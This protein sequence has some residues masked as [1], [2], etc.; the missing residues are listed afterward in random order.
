MHQPLVRQTVDH[1]QIPPAQAVRFT[2]RLLHCLTKPPRAG[3]VEAQ[4]ADRLGI[5]RVHRQVLADA[6]QPL[7]VEHHLHVV[8][9]VTG[10]AVHGQA[11]RRRRRR[12][13]ALDH[14]LL[15][16]RVAVEQ[17][18][19]ALE[20]VAGDP[21][22]AQVVRNLKERIELRA[23]RPAVVVTL[24][25]GL[26]GGGSIASDHRD[27]PD[28]GSQQGIELPLQQRLAVQVDEALGTI[29]GERQQAP[30]LAGAQDD[31]LHDWVRDSATRKTT[32]RDAVAGP[33]GP[34]AG[35]RLRCPG[36]PRRREA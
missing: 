2:Q 17:Q 14:R 35:R 30:A 8:I 29:G 23:H 11:D 3:G 32:D 10:L 12:Q 7:T 15:E 33:G 22:A 27:R 6:Q 9:V 36:R 34:V 26:D 25:Q 28:T 18:H 21:A 20:R 13:Q 16:H 1:R 31:G 19:I 5:D 24:Q 4:Q